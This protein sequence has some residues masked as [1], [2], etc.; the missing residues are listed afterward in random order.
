M[1]QGGGKYQQE[2]AL[3]ILFHLYYQQLKLF[4]VPTQIIAAV[5]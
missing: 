1:T 3:K 2:V 5:P 4:V